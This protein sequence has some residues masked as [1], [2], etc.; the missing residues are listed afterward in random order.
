LENERGK[1]EG[2]IEMGERRG[3]GYLKSNIELNDLITTAAGPT[4]HSELESS[5]VINTPLSRSS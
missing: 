5:K 4:I 2:P 3:R 1:R